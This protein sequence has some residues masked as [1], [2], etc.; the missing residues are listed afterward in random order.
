LCPKDNQNHL[1]FFLLIVHGIVRVFLRKMGHVNRHIYHLVVVWQTSGGCRADFQRTKLYFLSL[2]K[3]RLHDAFLMCVSMSDKPFDAEACDI[4]GQASATNGLSDMK[5]HIETAPCN[6]PPML[7]RRMYADNQ[8]T[9]FSVTESL[10]VPKM[11]PDTV[12]RQS[13]AALSNNKRRS[14]PDYHLSDPKYK[15]RLSTHF[16]KKM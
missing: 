2:I 5:T 16:R 8:R 6:R 3:G 13:A 12:S 11:P 9:S 15:N 14:D 4:G 7:R 10:P 1:L